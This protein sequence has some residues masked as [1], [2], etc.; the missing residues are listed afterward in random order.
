MFSLQL[1]KIRDTISSV[2]VSQFSCYN[3]FRSNG[4]S[5]NFISYASSLY[6]FVPYKMQSLQNEPSILLTIRRVHSSEDESPAI[7]I[8][9]H[10]RAY[11]VHDRNDDA[12]LADILFRKTLRENDETVV[13][14]L[15]GADG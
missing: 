2:L 6:D 7:L 3:F 11:H 14:L 4:L 8:S 5:Y 10:H 15:P 13:A 9:A 12:C 1:C